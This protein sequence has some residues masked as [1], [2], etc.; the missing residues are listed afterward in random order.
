MNIIASLQE[1]EDIEA[2]FLTFEHTMVREDVDEELF[3]TV[4][5]WQG[6]S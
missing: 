4:V 6:P 1:G 3:N 5:D 2:F